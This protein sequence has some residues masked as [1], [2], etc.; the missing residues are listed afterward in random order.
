M[1][2]KLQCSE[3]AIANADMELNRVKAHAKD[4]QAVIDDMQEDLHEKQKLLS[5]ISVVAGRRLIFP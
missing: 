3:V 4:Q 2:E 1:T 5:S